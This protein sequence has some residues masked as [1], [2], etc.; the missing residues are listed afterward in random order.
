MKLITVLLASFLCLY[1][2]AGQVDGSSSGTR[3]L[4]L[5]R[6]V[7]G[8]GL[9]G[10]LVSGFGLSFRH[11][12]PSTF[13]YQVVGGI[14]KGGQDLSY[15]I[16]GEIQADIMRGE[17]NRF[18]ACGGMGY[19]FVGDTSVNNLSAPVRFG[20]GVGNEWSNVAQFHV[21]AEVMLTFFNDGIIIPLPQLSA[22]YY[23]F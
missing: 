9:S 22:H 18:Y 10:G 5:G 21:A 15:N 23:F 3:P 12:L 19:F 7:Y 13:S 6:N 16:A 17:Q 14:I 11:H 1:T 8:L 20:V 2:A 4:S